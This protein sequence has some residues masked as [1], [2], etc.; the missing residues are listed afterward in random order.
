M[1]K[2]SR[3]ADTSTRVWRMRACLE[4]LHVNARGTQGLHCNLLL[5]TL[6]M[7]QTAAR[8]RLEMKRVRPHLTLKCRSRRG[9]RGGHPQFI[10][11]RRH[12]LDRLNV[13]HH[14]NGFLCLAF[15]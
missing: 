14:G 8:P 3:T 4:R 7:A 10:A 2:E 11:V 15:P 9:P 6:L 12:A 13:H 5:L 1:V